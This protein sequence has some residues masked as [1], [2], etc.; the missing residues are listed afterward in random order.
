[1]ITTLKQ[2]STQ[3]IIHELLEKFFKK[4]KSKGV[5]VTKYCGVL[6]L[7]EDAVSLQKQMRDEWR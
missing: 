1:M 2:G 3:K 6:N 5:D 4:K 7:D